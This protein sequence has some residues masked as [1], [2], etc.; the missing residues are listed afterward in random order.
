MTLGNKIASLRKQAGL[1]QEALAQRLE[2]TNQAVSKWESD[3]CCPDILLLP[4][5]ADIFGI[6]MDELFGREAPPAPE[7]EPEPEPEQE[8]KQKNSFLEDILGMAMD[9]LGKATSQFKQNGGTVEIH[10]D[11]ASNPAAEFHFDDTGEDQ[12]SEI[13]WPDDDTLRVVLFRGHKLLQGHKACERIQFCYD[14]PALNIHSHFNVTC[15][16][17][18]GNVTAGGNV[19]CN[20]VAGSVQAGGSVTCDDVNGPVNAMGNV[21][22][23]A[24]EG[25]VSAGGN[26]RCDE[27]TGSTIRAGGNIYCDHCEMDD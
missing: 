11:D 17:V 5:I 15:E 19:T 7:K 16:D 26:I 9:T 13:D 20:E 25:S 21:T 23:D 24:I 2:V 6:S 4:K 14:G 18:S 3:Q 22:C 1:T 10:Y 8:P 12:F 27:I